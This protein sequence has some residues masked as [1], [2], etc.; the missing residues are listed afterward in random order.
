MDLRIL[1]RWRQLLQHPGLSGRNRCFSPQENSKCCQWRTFGMPQED[2]HLLATTFGGTASIPQWSRFE[3]EEIKIESTCL[4]YLSHIEDR[5]LRLSPSTC[6]LLDTTF[7]KT[8]CYAYNLRC[9]CLK[10]LKLALGFILAKH[11]FSFF[12][13]SS[14]GA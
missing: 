10:K 5:E 6:R 4:R 13:F 7:N 8:T 1:F 11:F 12:F 3:L 9:R 2:Q 14:L